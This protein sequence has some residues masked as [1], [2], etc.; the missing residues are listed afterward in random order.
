M[1]KSLL[2][3]LDAGDQFG[4]G[5]LS[6]CLVLA[7]EFAAHLPVKFIIKSDNREKVGS[8]L[9]HR[10]E[11]NIIQV[12]FIYIGIKQADDLTLLLDEFKRNKSILI[13]DHY[14]VDESYQLF[15][16]ENNIKWLQFDSYGN[17]PFYADL[18]LHGSPGA[19][20]D[21]YEPLSRNPK[22]EFLLGTKYAIVG[23]HFV[24]LR[25][26]ARIRN[27]AKKMMVCFGGGDDRGA[28][29]SCLK[30]LNR[31]LLKSIDLFVVTSSQN[32]MLVDIKRTLSGFPG[33]EL[34]I[35]TNNIEQIMLEADLAILSPG[36]LSYEAACLGLP[37]VQITIADNQFMNAAGWEKIGCA[38][39]VGHE[40]SYTAEKLNA[41]LIRLFANTEK[42]ESMSN[43]C[44]DVVDGRGAKR[45]KNKI[46]DVI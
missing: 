36:M 43:A 38:E 5:H 13:L 44:F 32:T 37:M 25:K 22:T 14:S 30:N 42:L 16:K 21:I 19:T 20:I 11:N 15:L 8:F 45:V 34:L 18:V 24:D 6:R 31:D 10:I 2:F 28:T 12:S 17:M 33:A 1:K 46:L 23:K 7:N 29:L 35:D 41:T 27:S 4:M 3:R 9:E 39:Y 40:K 26:K